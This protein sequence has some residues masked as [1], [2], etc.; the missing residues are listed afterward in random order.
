MA[1][2]GET[3]VKIGSIFLPSVEANKMFERH[4]LNN[5]MQVSLSDSP[6]N[7]TEQLEKPDSSQPT[8][9]IEEVN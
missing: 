1:G 8:P 6:I 3:D 5:A 7:V 4:S 9:T 2:D